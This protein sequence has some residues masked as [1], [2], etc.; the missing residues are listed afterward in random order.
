M[1]IR[2]RLACFL[3]RGERRRLEARIEPGRF[4]RDLSGQL[5]RVVAALEALEVRG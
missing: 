5:D 1:S 3:L 4:D 2:S